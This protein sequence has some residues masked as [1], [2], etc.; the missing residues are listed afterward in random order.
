M[1]LDYKPCRINKCNA[2]FT[3]NTDETVCQGHK[4]GLLALWRYMSLELGVNTAD[5]WEAIKNVVVKTI[6]RCVIG[7]ILL[8]V[9]RVS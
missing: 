4:W 8:L 6:I 2:D 5:I 7:I 9:M 3:P 1:I